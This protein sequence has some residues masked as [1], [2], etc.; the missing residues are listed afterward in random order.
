MEVENSQFTR[1]GLFVKIVQIFPEKKSKLSVKMKFISISVFVA[2]GKSI[3]I[4]IPTNKGSN[5]SPQK[6]R[7]FY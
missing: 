4:S 5:V 2:W 7:P 3:S 1:H 6:F